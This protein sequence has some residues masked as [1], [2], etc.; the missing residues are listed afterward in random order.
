MDEFASLFAG[1]GFGEAECAEARGVYDRAVRALLGAA[2]P[3]GALGDALV[4]AQPSIWHQAAVLAG[5]QIGDAKKLLDEHF[6]NDPERGPSNLTTMIAAFGFDRD[7]RRFQAAPLL[8][9]LLPKKVVSNMLADWVYAFVEDHSW[10]G[11][12]CC[13]AGAAGDA[14]RVAGDAGRVAGD[15]AAA[16]REAWWLMA[17]TEA[18]IVRLNLTGD[19]Y[20]DV[21]VNTRGGAN[22][23]VCAL[24]CCV[25][26]AAVRART[27]AYWGA[28]NECAQHARDAQ[29]ARDT[30]DASKPHCGLCADPSA[31]LA[32]YTH[33]AEQFSLRRALRWG[34]R[35]PLPFRVVYFQDGTA[36]W[37]WWYS[38][39][40]AT[41]DES[42][43]DACFPEVPQVV[44]KGLRNIPFDKIVAGENHPRG[45]GIMLGSCGLPMMRDLYLKALT[46]AARDWRVYDLVAVSDARQ[47]EL[48]IA[49]LRAGGRIDPLAC[50]V[51]MAAS[52]CWFG[53][54]GSVCDALRYHG[55][56]TF[57]AE[58]WR[59]YNC[60]GP[61]AGNDRGA[62]GVSETLNPV[63]AQRR[64]AA[65]VRH[66]MD[67]HAAGR[68]RKLYSAYAR[69]CQ[70]K[71]T[72][73]GAAF[74]DVASLY[75]LY[76]VFIT[77]S[78]LVRSVGPANLEDTLE[79][80][81]DVE[82]VVSKILSRP[83]GW[84]FDPTKCGYYFL[85][86]HILNAG[87]QLIIRRDGRRKRG[88]PTS[89]TSPTN[90][91]AERC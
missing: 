65:S 77:S 2:A 46:R 18:L 1:P 63:R 64:L 62:A 42:G 36:E 47:L 76:P 51:T 87:W 78:D 31:E 15:R 88:L 52:V 14:G 81:R 17:V 26:W 23:S 35:S 7:P 22:R 86:G 54:P 12:S 66:F 9:A 69:A 33:A 41:F 50:V 83:F 19:N 37:R 53:G 6:T 5:T 56:L 59:L 16:W 27:R 82:V 72:P 84:L 8:L 70:Y 73:E 49:D 58:R 21:A 29:N 48:S 44:L 71:Q 34:R 40:A 91:D 20:P 28:L 79:L 11:D 24:W 68:Q 45:C 13:A 4:G 32:T 39:L 85:P 61:I 80:F 57:L 75:H 60:L 89:P 3:D 90:G 55:R 38:A 10:C 25:Q 30:L 67:G 43:S 74:R